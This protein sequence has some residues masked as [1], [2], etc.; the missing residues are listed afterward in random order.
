M[1][2]HKRNAADDDT[3]DSITADGV[4]L[5]A[6]NKRA[7]SSSKFLSTMKPLLEA[8]RLKCNKRGHL[9]KSHCADRT[10]PF[11]NIHGASLKEASCLGS[12]QPTIHVQRLQTRISTPWAT[13]FG[14]NGGD[15]AFL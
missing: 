4:R 3:P 15:T 14:L 9:A 11:R 10:R 1:S 7:K 12:V 2:E 8:C 13:Q 5:D 6:Q